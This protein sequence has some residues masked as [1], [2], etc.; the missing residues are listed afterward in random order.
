M[1][2]T[3]FCIKMNHL[4]YKGQIWCVWCPLSV[5]VQND[6]CVCFGQCVAM[7][8]TYFLLNHVEWTTLIV[9]KQ[10]KSNLVAL[11]T[12]RYRCRR[13]NFCVGP[14]ECCHGYH[15]FLPKLWRLNNFHIIQAIT[16]KIRMYDDLVVCYQRLQYVSLRKMC[17]HS[18]HSFLYQ[19]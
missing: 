19:N 8:T 6:L 17:C 14:T 2:T 3:H 13:L 15:N 9:L 11:M 10:L 1:V 12:L 5:V 16:V 4:G 18:N 7:V